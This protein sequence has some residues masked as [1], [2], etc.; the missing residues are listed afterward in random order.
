[1]L[2][3]FNW[4][5]SLLIFGEEVFWLNHG[6]DGIQLNEQKCRYCARAVR[7]DSNRE[8]DGNRLRMNDRRCSVLDEQQIII[9]ECDNGGFL[10]EGRPQRMGV[11]VTVVLY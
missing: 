10:D 3:V 11:V 9:K 6:V 7:F 2:L 8:A 1:M 4:R 5:T